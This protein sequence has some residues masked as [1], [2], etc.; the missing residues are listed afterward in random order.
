MTPSSVLRAE[1]LFSGPTSAFF[2][3]PTLTSQF[4]SWDDDKRTR[5]G[6]RSPEKDGQ[7]DRIPD[8]MRRLVLAMNRWSHTVATLASVSTLALSG[9]CSSA[10]NGVT[11]PDVALSAVVL[12]PKTMTL[13][14]NGTQQLTLTGTYNDGTTRDLTAA[15]GTSYS[16]SGGAVSATGLYTAPSA[17][18]AYTIV[19][20]NGLKTD[21]ANVVVAPASTWA[22]VWSDEFTGAANSAI[23][24]T[25]WLFDIG[26]SYPGAAQNWGTGE[27]ETM[28][29]STANVYLDGLGNLAINPIRGANGTWTSGRIETQRNDFE[30]PANG[31]LAVE[32]SI[33]QPNVTSVNGLGYW[34]AF[35]MLGGPFRNVYTNWPFIGEIDI[36]ENINGMNAVFGTFHCDRATGGACNEPTGRGSGAKPCV[37]CIGNFH[38]YRIEWDRS[39]TPQQIRWYLDGVNYFSVDQSQVGTA[40]WIA[41]TNHGFMIILD[42]A[43][44]GGFPAAFG[45]G[46][47]PNTIS[48]VPMLVDYVR[49]YQR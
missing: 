16:A 1:P 30:P 43:I 20:T 29:N 48:G 39:V 11:K 40:E 44:G 37:G 45:G 2:R 21:A 4:R 12:A 31:M 13:P 42:V 15:S 26:T 14:A 8:L 28:T 19:A 41:A 35:W 7:S 22:L 9:S 17:S 18:G 27:I 33:Q 32:A 24:G 23:D 36:L 49:V 38:V 47:T 46:P 34:P 3:R 10:T 5:N 6:C 25:K